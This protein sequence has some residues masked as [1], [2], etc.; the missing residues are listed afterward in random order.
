MRDGTN[1]LSFK[2]TSTD[3]DTMI[4]DIGRARLWFNKTAYNYPLYAP[5]GSALTILIYAGASEMA[6]TL[7]AAA[8]LISMF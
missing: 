1:D 8:A 7:V 5:Q 6:T 3:N 2:P 4:I